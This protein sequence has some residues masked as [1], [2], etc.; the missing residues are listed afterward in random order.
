MQPGCSRE[1]MGSGQGQGPDQVTNHPCL[2]P[3]PCGG[4]SPTRLFSRWSWQ[5]T[6]SWRR[7][8]WA[9]WRCY[10]RTTTSRR[11][12]CAL[13]CQFLPPCWGS[14]NPFGTSRG[15]C[16][17]P[18]QPPGFLLQSGWGLLSSG[19][20]IIMADLYKVPLTSPLLRGEPHQRGCPGTQCSP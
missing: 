17:S 7:V 15:P 14:Q 13:L 16:P 10:R 8:S 2:S 12:Y 4:W 1:A 11:W 3:S 18:G 6:V 9:W 19:S 20:Q 5:T